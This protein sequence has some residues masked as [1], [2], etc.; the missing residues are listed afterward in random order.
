MPVVHMALRHV[1]DDR[2]EA[3]QNCANQPVRDA[4]CMR[5]RVMLRVVP[6]FA[7]CRGLGEMLLSAGCRLYQS[8]YLPF[9]KT[10]LMWDFIQ[11]SRYFT[12]PMPYSQ[13]TATLAHDLISSLGMSY[14]QVWSSSLRQSCS[15]MVHPPRH[16]GVS[17][18]SIVERIAG[19]ILYC[20]HLKTRHSGVKN[21]R[22]ASSIWI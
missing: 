2:C 4:C 8:A 21:M 13:R 6:L 22:R 7:C 12:I 3:K 17:T 10:A 20:N 5:A 1:E 16:A 18:Y 11:W 19:E 15:N 14:Y 9:C